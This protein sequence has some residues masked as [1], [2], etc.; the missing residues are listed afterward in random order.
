MGGNIIVDK[1]IHNLWVLHKMMDLKNAAKNDV[2]G[3][4]DLN[5][6]IVVACTNFIPSKRVLLS[7]KIRV[8][9]KTP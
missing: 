5:G 4:I 1:S 3:M 8:C 9:P 6:R 7:F 2:F